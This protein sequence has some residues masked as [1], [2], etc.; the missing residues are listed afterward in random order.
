MERNRLH[1]DLYSG[2]C[3]VMD[4]F[5]IASYAADNMPFVAAK[6]LENVISH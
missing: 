3:F 1:D 2:L 5:V 6:N 4:F